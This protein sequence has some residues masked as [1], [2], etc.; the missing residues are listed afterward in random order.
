MLSEAKHPRISTMHVPT[1]FGDLILA[2]E[3]DPSLR[4]G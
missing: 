3:N 2:N 1:I 4:S